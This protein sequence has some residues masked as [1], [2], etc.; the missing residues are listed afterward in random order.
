MSRLITC[1]VNAMTVPRESDEQAHNMVVLGHVL[2][3]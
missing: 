3:L 1:L 2:N